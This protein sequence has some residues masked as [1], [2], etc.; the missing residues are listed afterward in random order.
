[1]GQGDRCFGYAGAGGS[2]TFADPDTKLGFGFSH[3]VMHTGVGPG[4]CGLPLVEAV[5]DQVYA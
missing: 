2:Y 5:L 3:N 1:M 4:P